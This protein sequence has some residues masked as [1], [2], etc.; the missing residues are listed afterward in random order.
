MEVRATARY[1]PISDQ[2]IRLVVDQVRGMAAAEALEVLY[3]MPQKGA[4][5][6]SKVIN[7]AI[8]NATKNF[9]LERE[10]LYIAKIYADKGPIR[11]WR[12]FGARGRLKPLLRRSS[13]V[14]V[15]L[16]EL[17]QLPGEDEES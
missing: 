11:R 8:H 14:T 4:P 16:D 15:V 5:M 17:E 13:H 3:H 7:S 1:L 12:R 2:K 9:S 6:V 10:R